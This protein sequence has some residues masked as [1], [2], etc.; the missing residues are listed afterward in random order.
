MKD[1]SGGRVKE[2]LVSA[3][4]RRDARG[5]NTRDELAKALDELETERHAM[6]ARKREA[7]FRLS[8]I[9]NKIRAAHRVPPDEYRRLCN[10]QT[11]LVKEV[12]ELETMFAD[13]NKR[14]HRLRQDLDAFERPNRT[15]E[16]NELLRAILAELRAMNARQS[17]GA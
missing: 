13:A 14:L 10:E 9:K 11:S 8:E 16:T 15:I 3:G 2:V 12:G 17:K 6:S 4:S 5:I 7:Q 1:V